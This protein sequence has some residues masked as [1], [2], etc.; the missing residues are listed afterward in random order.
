MAG[1]KVVEIKS[2]RRGNVDLADLQSKLSPRS[3]GLML[4]NPNTLGLFEDRIDVRRED[5]L[6]PVFQKE[7]EGRRTVCY[8][9][10]VAEDEIREEAQA[11]GISASAE[12]IDVLVRSGRCACEVRNPQGTCCLGNVFSVAKAASMPPADP[13]DPRS[14]VP[15]AQPVSR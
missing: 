13:R 12:R 3:A 2:D 5:V 8:C 7:P 11:T 15:S 1:M 14:L 9:F 10:E 4:T 6:L